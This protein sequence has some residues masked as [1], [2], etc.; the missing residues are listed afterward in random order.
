MALIE[1]SSSIIPIDP[2][3]IFA[4]GFELS[5]QTI[6]PS[7]D[8][9]GSFTP[10]LNNMEF[11]VYNAQNQIQ[12]SEYNFIDYSITNNSNPN[13]GPSGV[14][15]GNTASLSTTNIIDLNPEQDVYNV[16]FSNGK[17]TAV[18]N[19]INHELSS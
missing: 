4:D 14:Q 9:S 15:L 10:G 16:G 17:L 2:S 19:F 11:F 8:Y 18:Y 12:Y 6:I 1:V 3:E 5:Q 7:Q 13:A